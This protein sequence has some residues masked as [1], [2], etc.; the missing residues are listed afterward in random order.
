[1]KK[2][3]IITFMLI[4]C[5]SCIN[6]K[7]N[8][9]NTTSL[10]S[11][12]SISK[13]ERAI[14]IRD[15]SGIWAESEEENALFWIEKDSIY[16]V[17]QLGHGVKIEINKDTLIIYYDGIIVKD[18]ILKLDSDSLILLNEVGNTIKLYKRK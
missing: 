1:M 13:E 3:Y 10:Y 8:L 5:G 7:Q 6:K 11:Q 16:S 4:V 14:E 18:K 12:I 17:E 2:I 15:I 9:N